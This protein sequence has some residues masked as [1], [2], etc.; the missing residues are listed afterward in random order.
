MVIWVLLMVLVTPVAGFSPA[1]FLNKFD[2]FEECQSEQK[3]ISADMATAY[4]GD[5]SYRIEC[6][7]K[8]VLG[9]ATSAPSE[10]LN[11][12]QIITDWVQI[13]HPQTDIKFKVLSV[14]PIQT[15]NGPTSVIALQLHVFYE[16]NAESYIL[17]IKN[18]TVVGWI[19]AG[20]VES[21]TEE[22]EE[23]FSHKDQA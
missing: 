15:D 3:R 16:T 13:R 8:T 1:Y 7:E 22:E 4:T 12:T 10:Q 18:G 5:T 6:R 11:Y 17:F 14:K 23:V 2:T 21:E 20:V 9:I 19:Y